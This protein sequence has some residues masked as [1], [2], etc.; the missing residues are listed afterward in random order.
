M[1]NTCNYK[2]WLINTFFNYL[3][4]SHGIEYLSVLGRQMADEGTARWIFPLLDV[5]LELFLT[6]VALVGVDL[7]L[8]LALQVRDD[9]VEGAAV[10]V[11]DDVVELNLK[12]V[13]NLLK[14]NRWLSTN[15]RPTFWIGKVAGLPAEQASAPEIC[16]V[17]GISD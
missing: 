10:E 8:L 11:M 9:V 14:L 7:L 15:M 5:V 2:Y 17:V 16:L 13:F 6:N 3:V 4:L 12:F 1:E